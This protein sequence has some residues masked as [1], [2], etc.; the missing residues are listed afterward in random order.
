MEVFMLKY[1]II[2]LGGLGKSHFRAYDIIKKELGDEIKLVALCDIRKEAF[3]A[4][5]ATNLGDDT[6]S[7]DYSDYNL[8]YNVDDLLENEK[9]DF[10]VIV[11][12][13]Y[14]HEELAVKV[15]SKGINVFS[16]KPMA[17]TAEA[18][19]NMLD[20]SRFACEELSADIVS[21]TSLSKDDT[22][23]LKQKID[24]LFQLLGEKFPGFW[25]RQIKGDYIECLIPNVSDSFRIALII[26]SYI[27]S[28]TLPEIKQS[29]SFQTYGIRIAIGIGEMRIVDKQEGILDGEAIYLSGRAIENMTSPNKGTLSIQINNDIHSSALNTIAI[30]TDALMN[31]ATKRQSEVLFYKLLSVK[32]EDIADKLGIKQPGVNNHS[33]SAKWYC[34]EEALNYF[35]QIKF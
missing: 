31:N 1:A 26:K 35:E 5:V 29:K 19:K 23:E 27:K 12:P 6:S 8:Y 2:G 11:V 24:S 32:E 7:K 9:L 33:S 20:A 13:T 3:T 21:S 28:I 22:I 17:I 15:M 4:T 34:I 14:L 30:L 25:G 10:A 16:E 18:A